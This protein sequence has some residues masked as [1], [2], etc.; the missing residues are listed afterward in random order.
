MRKRSCLKRNGCY[1]LVLL[2]CVTSLI[3]CGRKSSSKSIVSGEI[4]KEHIFKQEDLDQVLDEGESVSCMEYVGGKIILFAYSEKGTSRYISFNPDGTEVKSF[5]LCDG[6]K[7]FVRAA[8]FDNSDNAYIRCVRQIE[9]D[10]EDENAESTFED[11]DFLIKIDTTGKELFGLD[12]TKEASKESSEEGFDVSDI[13]WSEKYG[14]ICFTPQGIKTYDEKIGFRKFMDIQDVSTVENVVKLT[15][16]KILISNY[17]V[18]G[19]T[20]KIIDLDKKEVGENLN[21]FDNSFQHSF[22]SGDGSRVYMMDDNGVYRYDIKSE[23]LKKLIDFNDSYIGSEEFMSMF[24]V[25]IV[26][27]S[28][29]EFIAGISIDEFSDIIVKFTKVKPEDVVDKTIITLSSIH[30]NFDTKNAIMRFNRLNDKY[31]IKMVNYSELYPNDF[32]ECEK[33]FDLDIISGKAADIICVPVNSVKKYADKGIFLDLTPA[34]EKGGELEDVEFLPNI[35]EMQKID[36]K[37]FSFIT[38]FYV[39]TCV[40]R[41]SF[42]NGRKTLTYRDCDDIIKNVGTDYDIAFGAYNEKAY[43]ASYLLPYYGNKFIDWKNKRC[44]FKSSEFKDL[45]DFMNKFPDK[46]KGDAA[47]YLFLDSYYADDRAVFDIESF[48]EIDNYVRLKQ[49]VFHEDIALVGFPNNSGENLASIDATCFAV[50]SKTPYK[51]IILDFIKELIETDSKIHGGGFPALRSRFEAHLQDAT[52]E[53]SDDDR[54]AYLYDETKDELIKMKPLSQEEI[55]DFYDYVVSIRSFEGADS[56]VSD[57]IS[58]EVSAYFSGQKTAEQVAE[59]IQN[60]VNVYINENS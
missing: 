43:L 54:S 44:D 6:N 11:K 17:D 12:L 50:N 19:E 57:I 31:M 25:K 20:R 29:T 35:A 22:F 58:E 23:G 47:D 18:G 53:R 5:D 15:D 13:V 36:G 16:N 55:R 27:I 2:L 41:N 24:F 1:C 33:Q 30:L 52:K 4:D 7:C 37:T 21:G 45:L 40:V 26:A 28:D 3:G 10:S 56:K 9:K 8:T 14:L 48:Y 46:R 49:A 34:F 42:A 59:I 60:R 32:D 39:N 51:E 38:S